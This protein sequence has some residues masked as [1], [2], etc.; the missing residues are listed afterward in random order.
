[1]NN[2]RRTLNV[3]AKHSKNFPIVSL[4]SAQC[5]MHFIISGKSQRRGRPGSS[6]V[7]LFLLEV[8]EHHLKGKSHSSVDEENQCRNYCLN[9]YHFQHVLAASHLQ[10]NLYSSKGGKENPTKREQITPGLNGLGF[11]I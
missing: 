11:L 8:T 3:K 1:M 5:F 10:Y 6:W 2:A 7:R 4:A 9:Q